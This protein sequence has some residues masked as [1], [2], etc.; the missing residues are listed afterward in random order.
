M[1]RKPLIETLSRAE[2][3][4]RTEQTAQRLLGKTAKKAYEMLDA[5]KLEGTFAGAEL[6]FLR[7]LSLSAAKAKRRK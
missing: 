6:E 5:G 7:D 1:A 2:F 3:E 4:E